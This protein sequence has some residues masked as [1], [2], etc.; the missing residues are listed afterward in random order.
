[1]TTNFK[2]KGIFRQTTPIFLIINNYWEIGATN[3]FF[4]PKI[5]KTTPVGHPQTVMG[6]VD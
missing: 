6:V 2:G 5:R 4:F 3:S 1:M